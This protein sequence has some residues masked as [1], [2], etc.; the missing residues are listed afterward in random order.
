M[1]LSHS[2]SI[3][4]DGLMMYYDQG[5]KKSW[6]GAP[7]SNEIVA[8]TWAGD[9][10]TQSSFVPES[11]LITDDNLKY[12]GL[13]TYLY[14][15]GASL[16]CYLNGAD[17]STL[18][19]STDW[20]FS[21]YIRRQDGADITALSS[22]MYF[23]STGTGVCTIIPVGNGWHFIYRTIS[24]T[25][26]YLSL[27][28]FTGFA[29]NTKYYLSGA[30]LSKT[31]YPVYPVATNSARTNTQSI[32]DL[33]SKSTFTANNLTYS[34][35]NTF[36]FSGTGQHM[37]YNAPAMNSH[38]IEFV[39]FN[40]GTQSDTYPTIHQQYPQQ[41]TYGYTW[42]YISGNS[43]TLTY[44]FATTT[45]NSVYFASAV[46]FGVYTH[47]T[48]VADYTTQ[49]I[50]MYKNGQISSTQAA[51]GI[52]AIPASTAYIGNYQGTA[53]TE[54][55]LVGKLPIYKVYNIALTAGQVSQNFNALRGRFG[56]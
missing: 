20:T 6:K 52:K 4:T 26:N 36:E 42:I 44:Q 27:V 38:T 43:T 22:Y 15:P 55:D 23:P 48:F 28:G 56:I 53:N 30:M 31:S 50:T 12:N 5:N 1:S 37:Y 16:N 47:I 54:Y 39:I 17:L 35:Y 10:A 3:V 11:I 8:V 14:S 40:P 18:R 21:C 32:V 45:T 25:L 9:G 2:P 19:T 13:E 46:P 41:T 49:T 33:M 24:G 34:S 29:A 7:T 51:T